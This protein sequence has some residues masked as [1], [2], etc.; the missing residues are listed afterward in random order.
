MASHSASF[1]RLLAVACWFSLTAGMVHAQSSTGSV[2]G[3]I[4]DQSQAVGATSDSHF[5]SL[6]NLS[7]GRISTISSTFS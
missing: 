5:K 3:T 4:R 7:P 6:D 2:R 1:R